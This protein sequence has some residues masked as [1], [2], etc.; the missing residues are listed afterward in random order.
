[1]SKSI[2]GCPDCGGPV[3]VRFPLHVCSKKKVVE[4][5]KERTE[6]PLG[7]APSQVKGLDHSRELVNFEMDEDCKYPNTISVDIGK[8][9]NKDR[10]WITIG[11][12]DSGAYEHKG[13]SFTF[14]RR[15][16]LEDFLNK[17]LRAG[18]KAFGEVQLQSVEGLC[19][20]HNIGR[21]RGKEGSKMPAT[22]TAK[23]TATKERKAPGVKATGKKFPAKKA[24]K[25]AKGAKGGG[26][27]PTG[28]TY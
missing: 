24:A 28:G 18:I 25:S 9:R 22:K 5:L 19:I 6:Q 8:S 10:Q 16:Q 14:E 4:K 27:K 23:G 26:S 3:S 13:E 21:D 1:M 2:V 15:E 12:E 11:V 7:G 20:R 17:T